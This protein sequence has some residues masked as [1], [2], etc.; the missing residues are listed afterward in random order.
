M[1]TLLF[2]RFILVVFLCGLCRLTASTT[3]DIASANQSLAS[4]HADDA[5]NS[6]RML[7]VSPQ[8]S[9]DASPELWY[10]R[11]LAE[12]K[13]GDPVAASLSFRRALLLDP[14]LAPAREALASVLGPL[15]VPVTPGWR[16]QILAK[17]HPETLILGGAILGWLGA[18]VFVIFFVLVP[19]KPAF[20]ALGLSAFIL[21]HG[22]SVF[23]TFLDPRRIAPNLGVITTK[24]SPPLRATP[25]DSA[26]EQGKIS[27]GSLITIL[28]R[29][30]PWWYVVDGS[31]QPGWIPSTTVTPLLPLSG[32]S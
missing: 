16:D 5:L 18:L 2:L 13:T 22:L 10:D 24:S 21:G 6:Y 23:G 32:G 11:G 12:E 19:R 7:L 14:T 4:G 29:N 27:P 20:I 17:V 26:T 9:K 3:D 1:K 28:S 25:A 30:G 15:G 8:F 31:G